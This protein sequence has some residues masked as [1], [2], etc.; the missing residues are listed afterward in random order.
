MA[1]VITGAKNMK[2]IGKGLGDYG[3]PKSVDFEFDFD[4]RSC[5]SVTH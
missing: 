4:C 3:Y 2:S 1:D 5:N